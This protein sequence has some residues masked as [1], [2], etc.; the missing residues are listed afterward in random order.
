MHGL[1]AAL[2]ALASW[3]S[4]PALNQDRAEVSATTLDGRIYVAGGV[5]SAGRD[6]ASLEAFEPS[7][8]VWP[9]RAPMPKGLNHLGLAGLKRVLYVAGGNAGSNATS[10]LI[11]YD[12]VL[13]TWTYGATM[14]VR[15]AAHV[16]VA[17]AGRL[18]VV[19]GVGDE[20]GVTLSYDPTIDLWERRGPL[21][22]LRGHLSAAAIDHRIYLA[23]GRLGTPRHRAPPVVSD[24]PPSPRRLLSVLAT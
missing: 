1:L 6:V 13:D 14:P 10:D 2:I 16:L 23:G 22:P 19:G 15:R 21:L 18:F 3:T 20:P 24:P 7:V 17:A 5:D 4:A 11:A 9:L 12:P 8:C